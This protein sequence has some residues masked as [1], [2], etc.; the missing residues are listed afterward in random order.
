MLP[1]E[2]AKR[3]EELAKVYQATSKLRRVAFKD[4]EKALV[5]GKLLPVEGLPGP[6]FRFKRDFRGFSTGTVVA[7]GFLMPGFPS[8]PRIFCLKTG[9]PRYLPGPFFAEEKIEGY[10]VRLVRLF[11]Q[12]LAFTRRG[13]I[14]PFATDRWPDFLPDLPRFFDDHPELVLCCEVAGPENPFVTE[15]P[16]HVKEDIN[17]FVFDLLHLKTGELLPPT[18]KYEL[19]KTYG[20]PTPE[21]NGPFQAK[22]LEAIR[23]LILRYDREGREGLVF[24]P[25]DDQG[26]V[27]KYVTSRSNVNDLRVTFPFIGELDAS[28]IV[29]RLVRL[30]ITRFELS[31]PFDQAFYQELGQALFGEMERVL[32]RIAQGQPIEEVFRLRFRQEE[33][34]GKLLT[35]F[36]TAQVR[37][38]IRDIEWDG[39]HFRVEFAKIYPRATTFWANKLEG[40]AQI[41]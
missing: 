20:F 25:L 16:P 24:K 12:V 9:I 3:K 38:E 32:S 39:R 8:I 15:W 18:E 10:N 31:Q 13:Y 4:L 5:E 27:V 26:R 35:H 41:D 23:E 40:L 37:I 29:H 30:A 28:Y 7:E 17:F 21:I 14:C 33:T 11:G 6:V 19:L 1:R 36:R 22:D 34:L 2:L